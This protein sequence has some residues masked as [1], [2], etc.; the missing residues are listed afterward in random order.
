MTE[1]MNTEFRT[2]IPPKMTELRTR[3]S[4]STCNKPRWEITAWREYR[5]LVRVR[6]LCGTGGVLLSGIDT[7]L[8]VV[9]K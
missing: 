8:P 9:Y 2:T 4:T 7:L 3:I 5:P 6:K 1:Y